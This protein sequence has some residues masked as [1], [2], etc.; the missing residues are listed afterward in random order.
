[1]TMKSDPQKINVIVT[2]N[3][4]SHFKEDVE[5]LAQ[6]YIDI[7]NRFSSG[8]AAM[9]YIN[10]NSTNLVITDVELNDMNVNEFIK[11]VNK[12]FKINQ[13][14][15]VM[16]SEESSKDFVLD[17]IGAGCSGF[18]IRP[19]S[20]E[21]LKEHIKNVVDLEKF[22]EIEEELVN[23]ANEKI[24][25]GNYNSA[26]EDLQEVVGDGNDLASSYFEYGTK[27][28]L[29]KK[30][31]KA[32]IAFQ[33]A[34]K[35][36]GLY[37]KAYTGMAE[38][39]NGKGDKEKYKY[40]LEKAADEYAKIDN[41]QEV[42][43]LFTEILKADPNAPNPYN[44]LG[45]NLRKEGKFQLAKDAYF[46]ALNLDPQDENIHFNMAK[47]YYFA[48]DLENSLKYLQNALNINSY[49]EE[50]RILYKKLTGHNWSN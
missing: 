20:L 21:T 30:Y 28:L 8:V 35:M 26:I 47:S 14:P 29:N 32:I 23:E 43:K 15:V 1:M 9:D 10:Y 44:T 24:N 45:I 16:I 49:F 34:L 4:D 7:S 33:K 42:K 13:I 40:Y 46:Q 41:F 5:S 36:N 39:Y 37:I 3:N 2:T 11:N 12:N 19:Y 17:A 38:A 31:T 22:G 50:A 18:V 6:L 27:Y 48:N 25:A